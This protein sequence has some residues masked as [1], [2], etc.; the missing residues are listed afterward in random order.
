MKKNSF[1]FGAII[2]VAVL[3]TTALFYF[4]QLFYTANFLVDKKKSGEYLFIEEGDDFKAVLKRLQDKEL[5]HNVLAFAFVS[6]VRG[7]QQNVKPGRYYIKAGMGNLAVVNMLR[8]GAQEPVKITFN[9]IR[10]L[11]V[12]VER[13]GE[14]LACGKAK[15]DKVLR[16]PEILK[17]YN[18]DTNNIIGFF[19]PNTYQAYWNAKPEAFIEQMHREYKKF[20]TAQREQQAK[21][22][23]LTPAQV[24]TLASIVQAETAKNDE[25]PRVAGVYLNRLRDKM[26]LQA[27]PT[28]VFALRDFSIKRLY[29]RHKEVESPYNTYKYVGLPPGPINM[30][31]Q[32]SIEA[33]LNPEKHKYLY[34][35]AKEDF[36]GYHNFAI[37]YNDHLR[38][39]RIY[40]KAL[41]MKGIKN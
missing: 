32:Q 12:L 9:N 33:V 16:S 37:N 15:F 38:N 3:L 39:A 20:W 6:Q 1:F 25:K 36:S 31:T 26:K 35:C 18:T 17:K 19:L 34:F 11:D 14:Q 13:V 41:D 29:D 28:L 27:D 10:T 21:N 23:K 5:I 30:P 4:Y 22:L 24:I 40:Q 2:F 8:A 7:Y